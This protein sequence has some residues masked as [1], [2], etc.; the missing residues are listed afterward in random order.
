MPSKRQ[1]RGRSL[2][3]RATS[4]RRSS[5]SS[6]A[7]ARNR[8]TSV[9]SFGRGTTGLGIGQYNSTGGIPVW[10]NKRLSRRAKKSFKRTQKGK[11]RDQAVQTFMRTNYATATSAI[12]TQSMTWTDPV[13]TLF[14]TADDFDDL[15]AISA[16]TVLAAG[17][18]V[19]PQNTV[20]TNKFIVGCHEN[21]EVS[22]TSTTNLIYLDRYDYSCKKDVL[23]AAMSSLSTA[24]TQLAFWNQNSGA[25]AYS[26]TIGATPFDLRYVTDRLTITKKI[27]YQIE[28][29]QS[30]MWDRKFKPR[31]FDAKKQLDMVTANTQVGLKGW[32]SGSILVM[33]GPCNAAQSAITTAA[34]VT[35]TKRYNVK[36]IPDTVNVPTLT[37]LN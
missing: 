18:T 26:T 34:A 30:V 8:G 11:L 31:Y 33:V 1:K 2:T 29:G 15:Q 7:S 12:N 10:R 21:T 36:L 16:T 35:T 19:Y 37:V 9:Q 4:A 5:A 24:G 22:N 6:R 25:Q 32:T 27:S 14:G 3:R 13:F 17:G 23:E 28:P 20:Y